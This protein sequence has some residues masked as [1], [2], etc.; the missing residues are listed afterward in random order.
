MRS[1]LV[2]KKKKHTHHDCIYKHAC[3]KQ[4]A[5]CQFQ[6]QAAKVKEKFS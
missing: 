6:L 4:L 2:K 3:I 1:Q 5:T